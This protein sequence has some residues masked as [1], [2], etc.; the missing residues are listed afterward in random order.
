MVTEGI[1]AFFP[2]PSKRASVIKSII[3]CFHASALFLLDIGNE[4]DCECV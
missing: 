4:M 1:F 3:V 2:N